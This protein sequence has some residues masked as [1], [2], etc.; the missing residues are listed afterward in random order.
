MGGLQAPGQE[1]SKNPLL[2]EIPHLSI[3]VYNN[4][5]EKE[6]PYV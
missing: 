3:P 1:E 4:A 2:P 5:I 6:I